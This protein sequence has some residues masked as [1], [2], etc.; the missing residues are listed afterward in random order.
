MSHPPHNKCC[1]KHQT[2]REKRNWPKILSK[3]M[4]WSLPRRSVKQRGRKIRKTMSGVSWTLG[5]PGTNAIDTPTKTINVGQGIDQDRVQNANTVT[6]HMRIRTVDTSR[7]QTSLGFLNCMQ[8]CAGAFRG[9]LLTVTRNHGLS[10]NFW[11]RWCR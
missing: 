4:K 11:Y 10:A 5:S 1:N 3:V 2:N 8:T 9:I 6:I 7:I